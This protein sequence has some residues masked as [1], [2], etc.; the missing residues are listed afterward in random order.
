MHINISNLVYYFKAKKALL[1]LPNIYWTWVFQ[2]S[3]FLTDIITDVCWP[4]SAEL[5]IGATQLLGAML[6]SN[7]GTIMSEGCETLLPAV[8]GKEEEFWLEVFS[9]IIWRGVADV[10]ETAEFEIV[11]VTVAPI[12]WFPGTI[13]SKKKIILMN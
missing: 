12:D 9:M 1:E 4:K 3:A 8:I 7:L 11:E 2:F 13:T 5:D 6:V 10:D